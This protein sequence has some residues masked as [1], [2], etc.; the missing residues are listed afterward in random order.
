MVVIRKVHLIIK[1]VITLYE[2]G[3]GSDIQFEAMMCRLGRHRGQV[4]GA[5]S[6]HLRSL[7]W[8]TLDIYVRTS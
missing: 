7:D 1:L 5:P 3:A 6:T 4:G 2:V 8:S